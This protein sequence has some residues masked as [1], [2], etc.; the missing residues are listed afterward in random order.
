MLGASLC[1][2]ASSLLQPKEMD[3]SF[4]DTPAGTK[5]ASTPT[6]LLKVS[7]KEGTDFPRYV[8]PKK[9]CK[10][11]KGKRGGIQYLSLS[12]EWW[13]CSSQCGLT[14][15][16]HGSVFILTNSTHT[17]RNRMRNKILE[18]VSVLCDPSPFPCT[19]VVMTCLTHSQKIPIVLF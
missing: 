18:T 5:Q 15:A 2:P 16:K 9:R 6:L 12:T 3:S 7:N 4:K 19:V 10:I 11:A 1:I 8:L 14:T 13:K 17:F